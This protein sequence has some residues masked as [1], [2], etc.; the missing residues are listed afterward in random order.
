[1]TDFRVLRNADTGV[2]LLD[3]VKWCQSYWCHFRGLML[4]RDLPEDEG[5]LFVY[6]RESRVDTSIHM[7]FMNFA[8]ATVWLDS[9]G[10]VVDKVLEFV[11]Q[12]ALSR[13][14]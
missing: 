8:I 11:G 7:L 9:A 1:M 3:R 14:N 13:T 4:R 2:V 12:P 5:I 10:R 6:G